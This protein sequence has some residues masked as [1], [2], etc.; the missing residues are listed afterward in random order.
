MA[1]YR[2]PSQN[3]HLWREIGALSKRA[4]R[5]VVIRYYPVPISAPR[6]ENFLGPLRLYLRTTSSIPTNSTSRIDSISLTIPTN[7]SG[8]SQSSPT[9][10]TGTSSTSS[11]WR[12]PWLDLS[13]FLLKTT[14]SVTSTILIL[15]PLSQ[16]HP[17]GGLSSPS[18]RSF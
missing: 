6:R 8:T 12:L 2:P 16:S 10:P 11:T 17:R 18:C 3:R 9:S 1:M 14:C 5:R 7:P 4:H 13:H 15:I